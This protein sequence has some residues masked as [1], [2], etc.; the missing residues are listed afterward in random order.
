MFFSI[1][2]NFNPMARD[3]FFHLPASKAIGPENLSDSQHSS[4][5]WCPEE[6]LSSSNHT[7]LQVRETEPIH[8]SLV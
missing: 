2:N 7:F 3:D 8:E 6:G 5:R 4:S 1:M